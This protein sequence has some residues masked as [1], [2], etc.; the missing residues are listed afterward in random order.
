MTVNKVPN[1]TFP[2]SAA[3]I[4]FEN[5]KIDSISSDAFRGISLKSVSFEG[6][7]LKRL[8]SGAF[9]DRTLINKVEFNNCIIQSISSGVLTAV[10]YLTIENST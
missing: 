7:T 6:T 5:C 8:E 4:R 2:L 1:A 3:K 9:S 10:N